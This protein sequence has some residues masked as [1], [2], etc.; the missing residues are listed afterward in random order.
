VVKICRWNGRR[1]YRSSCDMFDCKSGN[2][3]VCPTHFN[4]DGRFHFKSR[5]VS[6]SFEVY[7]GG[8][9]FG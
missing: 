8:D 4:P 9:G 6:D 5:K 7:V 2:V 1:C 3:L